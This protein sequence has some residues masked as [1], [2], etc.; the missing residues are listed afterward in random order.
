MKIKTLTGTSIHAALIEARRLYGDDVVLLESIPAEGEAPAR[1]TVM[2]DT[3]ISA[4]AE[5]QD[6]SRPQAVASDAGG[7][8]Y[9]RAAF[10]A[11][12]TTGVAEVAASSARYSTQRS[13]LTYQGNDQR[14]ENS[15]AHPPA[16]HPSLS[17]RTRSTPGQA[18]NRIF[19]EKD[20]DH[21]RLPVRADQ[22][23][24][25][26]E[27]QLKLIHNRLD[28]LDRRFEGAIVGAS[29][30][31]TSH[32]LFA[33]LLNQG[34]RPSTVTRLFERLMEK[35]LEPDHDE[36]KM[37][38]AL[39]HEIRN[40]L[41]T[42][43]PRRYTGTIM[44]IGPSGAGK[45]SLLLKI[46]RHPSFFGRHNTMIISVVPE[47]TPTIPYQNPAS[48][49]TQFEIPVQTVHNA[50]EMADALDRA[51]S[52]DQILID[53]PSMPVHE[54]RARKMLLN[55]KRIIEPLLP[56][57]VH[58]VLNATRALDEFDLSYIQRL[59]IRPDAIAFT[60][61]DETQGLGRL[62]EWMMQTELPVQFASSSPVVPDG[63]GAFTPSWFV[64]EMMR[65][66]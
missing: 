30:R 53:T 3:P 12:S 61:L 24:E 35:G 5:R 8:G 14:P 1:I 54:S 33:R 39:A 17:K 37:R 27:A 11:A 23:Q 7:Y 15:G 19:D 29:I 65:I 21:S 31:W 2:V 49:F 55:L 52:F 28:R 60:H 58:L 36:Q 13:R 38:W 16:M 26:L 46:A 9:N 57:Q 59:P 40:L 62:A 34:M 45:T 47:N 42:A 66:L 50:R 22:L 6:A 63:V 48:L 64:E 20:D 25:L 32:I 56:I 51:N 18:R 10:G 43:T 41:Q 4:P 44:L